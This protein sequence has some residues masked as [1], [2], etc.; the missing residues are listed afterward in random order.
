LPSD[1][2]K[3]YSPDFVRTWPVA[4]RGRS[5]Q[6][7]VPDARLAAHDALE[8][9]KWRTVT[10]R[11]GTKGPLR[12]RSR[13]C[14]FASQTERLP[15]PENARASTSQVTKRSGLGVSGDRRAKVLAVEP[16][17][18]EHPQ[19]TRGDHQGAVA[20]RAGPS[21]AQRGT[22]PRSLRDGAAYIAMLS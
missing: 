12:A 1:P 2:Q 14:E 20:V 6:R 21:A 5:R 8:L 11:R 4:P 9:Q 3:V 19:N 15:A 18:D 16:P 7:L 10:W 13:R 17:S 22:W